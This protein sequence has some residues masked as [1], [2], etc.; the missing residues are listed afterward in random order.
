METN[1]LILISTEKDDKNSIKTIPTNPEETP[2]YNKYLNFNQRVCQ[3]SESQNQKNFSVIPIGQTYNLRYASN[4]NT[5]D[6]LHDNIKDII[7]N[8]KYN[9][10]NRSK[11]AYSKKSFREKFESMKLKVPEI[12][13]WNCD[14][15]AEIIIHNL[16]QKI[17]ILTYEN[18]LLSKQIKEL[19]SNNKG[20]QLDLNQKI[21]LLKTEQQINNEL[22]MS[23]NKD[24]IN[25]KKNINN[26]NKNK[27]KNKDKDIDLYNEN[28][29]LKSE[30]LK[31]KS[32]NENL[33]NN[34]NDLNKIIEKLKNEMKLNAA[35][36]EEQLENNKIEYEN[37]IAKL[38]EQNKNNKLLFEKKLSEEN[39]KYKILLEKKLSEKNNKELKELNKNIINNSDYL[40]NNNINNIN[41]TNNNND[42]LFNNFNEKSGN[43][44]N[45]DMNKNSLNEDQLKKLYEENEKL[46]KHLRELL[47][48]DDEN[49]TNINRISTSFPDNTQHFIFTPIKDNDNDND[50]IDFNTIKNKEQ[51]KNDTT[52][53]N[54]QVE[55]IIKEN[56][57]LKEKVKSLSTELNKVLYDHNQK[58]LKIQQKFNEYELKNKELLTKDNTINNENNQIDNQ[59]EEE[60]DLILNETLLMN[61]N[62]EDEETKKMI[63]TI[64]N[65]NNNQK[66]R[67]SQCLI[68]NNKLKALSEQN[69]LLQ[70]QIASIKKEKNETNLLNMN[71]SLNNNNHNFNIMSNPQLH[72]HLCY[73]QNGTHESYDYL[74]NALKIKDQIIIKYKEQNEEN[75]NKYKK[76]I[77]ENSKL[78]ER[79][80]NN[81]YFDSIRQLN[82]IENNKKQDNGNVHYI[83]KDVKFNNIRRDR[84]A[85]LEDYLLGKIVNNQK[86][87]LGERAPRFDE[88]NYDFMS[89]SVQYQDNNNNKMNYRYNNNYH[90]REKRMTNY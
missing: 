75:E 73:C 80:S 6:N 60:L 86:E 9:N 69:Y 7:N 45:F 10:E 43:N 40:D 67:I 65:I 35:K 88:N 79:N 36:F 76:L 14:P 64:Q 8:P 11:S 17:D 42:N 59:K 12:K 25:E 57:L 39:E 4:S 33:A 87:V 89:K 20:L 47:C 77:I 23:Q 52:Y 56:H 3:T 55:E 66:K 70:N 71:H 85:G 49:E 30:N 51:N 74:I 28:T 26:S 46:H 21:L 31:I 34:I 1:N 27:N 15:T 68:I 61:I 83:K 63:S 44:I 32:N 54:I 13:K 18:F 29:L 5:Y 19:V 82:D 22:K 2:I 24:D 62:S 37:Q 48:I 38:E 90:Y 50:N 53:N 78:K 81:N 58:L 16:E 41:N 84:N 72:P